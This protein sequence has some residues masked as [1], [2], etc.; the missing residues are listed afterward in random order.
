MAFGQVS[1]QA[2][3]HYFQLAEHLFVLLL[4]KVNQNEYLFI[5]GTN[6]QV[7]VVHR[8]GPKVCSL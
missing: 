5:M 1:G 6:Y 2:I 4:Y 7:I 8:F 3:V